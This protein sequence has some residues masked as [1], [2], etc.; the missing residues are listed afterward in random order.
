M[1]SFGTLCPLSPRRL[2]RDPP[3]HTVD[4]GIAAA[5]RRNARFL[6]RCALKWLVVRAQPVM[7]SMT[8]QYILLSLKQRTL[9]GRVKNIRC[10]LNPTIRS[11]C[12]HETYKLQRQW[13]DVTGRWNQWLW[14]MDNGLASCCAG[15]A[16]QDSCAFERHTN[17]V[18]ERATRI[19]KRCDKARRR[20]VLAQEY[21]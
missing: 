15:Q 21:G 3:F 6:Y 18:R 16:R 5:L 17:F 2:S 14:A 19:Q 12:P 9:S 20:C 7:S 1:L 4:S 11:Q 10:D 13:D 8:S